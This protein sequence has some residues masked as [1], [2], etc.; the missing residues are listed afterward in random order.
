MVSEKRKIDINADMGESY[1]RWP[2]GKDEE[3]YPHIS[4]ANIAVGFHAGDPETI[5]KT[6]KDV[7]AAGVAPGAHPGLPDLMGFGRRRMHITPEE[8]YAYITLQAATINGV[9]RLTDQKLNHIKLHGAMNFV[10][11]W[12][13]EHAVAVTQAI[14][15]SVPN[16]TVYWRAAPYPDPFLPELQRRGVRVLR[17]LYPDLFYSPEGRLE[18]PRDRVFATPESAAEQVRRAIVDKQVLATDG[19]LI[20]LDFET[21][22]VHADNP[23]AVELTAGLAK[24]IEEE[25]CE[26]SSGAAPYEPAVAA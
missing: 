25:G 22:C 9:L 1:G 7:V 10:A 20:D 19:S 23:L 12:S 8:A 24:V 18:P 14:I 16:P 17:E 13:E 3:M 5:I 2:L 6:V 15:D 4:S 21:I 26:L 11:E